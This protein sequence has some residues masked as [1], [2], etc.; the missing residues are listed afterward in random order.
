MRM[1]SCGLV[2]T[3]LSF[4]KQ[5]KARNLHLNESEVFLIEEKGHT[6]YCGNCLKDSVKLQQ[7]CS[8]CNF[9]RSVCGDCNKK[10]L[11]D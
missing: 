9:Y 2:K 1:V 5:A 3:I 11:M 6:S 8:L 7:T 10:A 4:Y